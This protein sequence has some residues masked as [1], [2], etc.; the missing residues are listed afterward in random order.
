M[1]STSLRTMGSQ[2][3]CKMIAFFCSI[4]TENRDLSCTNA[5]VPSLA[6]SGDMPADLGLTGSSEL[7]M[8]DFSRL[9]FALLS[10]PPCQ[11]PIH[12][13]NTNKLAFS[14]AKGYEKA[15]DARAGSI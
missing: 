11:G 1:L 2:R 4:I 9:R 8:C 3:Q 6:A 12:D 15:F 5:C 14:Q 13:P 7:Q 10:A